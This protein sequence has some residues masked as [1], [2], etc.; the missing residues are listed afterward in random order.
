MAPRNSRIQMDDFDFIAGDVACILE[1]ASTPGWQ[2]LS[3]RGRSPFR[4]C[5]KKAQTAQ[6]L[7]PFGNSRA[8]PKAFVPKG[9]P[10]N[11]P[12]FQRWAQEQTE[13]R[14]EGTIELVPQVLPF[15]RPFG[16]DI[17]DDGLPA[18]KRRAIFNH[19]S[20]MMPAARL[21]NPFAK[22]RTA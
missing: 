4:P 22:S 6:M 21:R 8:A 12:A 16:T 1:R 13:P 7:M 18:L 9:H 14:P 3:G 10:E 2:N 11:S 20:G 15:G 17:T 19:P 5:R